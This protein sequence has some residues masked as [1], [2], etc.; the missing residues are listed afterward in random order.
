MTNSASAGHTVGYARVSTKR[1]NLDRQLDTLARLG[2]EK[3][4]TDKVTGRTMDR[5]EW[6]RCREYLRPGDT[7]AVDALDRLGRSAL[8]VIETIDELTKAGIAIV[9]GGGRRLDTSDPMGRALVSIM[10]VLAEMEVELKAERAAAAREAA[11]ARGKHTGRPKKL[12][13][14]E[15]VRARELRAQ[16]LS[17]TEVGKALG[18]SRATVYRYLGQEEVPVS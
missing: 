4:F 2:A 10:A 6:A 13:T 12:D 3:V 7:L 9:D 14:S 11:A 15:A 16:G 8:E 5:P 18:V 17:A 1:Q